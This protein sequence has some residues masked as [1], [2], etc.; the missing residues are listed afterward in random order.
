MTTHQVDLLRWVMG[1][2]AAVSASYSFDRLLAD[3]PT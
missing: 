2:V 1:E 3:S